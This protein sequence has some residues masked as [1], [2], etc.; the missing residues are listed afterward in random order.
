M[1]ALIKDCLTIHSDHKGEV[2]W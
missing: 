1:I 2:T